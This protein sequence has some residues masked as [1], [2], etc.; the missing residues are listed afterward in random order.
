MGSRKLAA[1]ALSLGL[2]LTLTACGGD[3]GNDQGRTQEQSQADEESNLEEATDSDTNVDTAAEFEGTPEEIDQHLSI[4]IP[5][6]WTM[7]SG[8]IP[9]LDIY[10]LMV[11]PEDLEREELEPEAGTA[12]YAYLTVVDIGKT[13]NGAERY[14]K[15]IMESDAENTD[16][17]SDL[18]E[19]E[20]VEV[21]ETM[22]Y[23][24]EGTFTQQG[25]V[26]PFQSWHADANGTTYVIDIHG[27]VEGAIPE[28][29]TDAFHSIRFGPAQY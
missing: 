5:D 4:T 6:G 28:E 12:D 27:D 11:V 1:G 3:E 19:L 7:L 26:T 15:A 2:L 22:F 25:I 9:G 8:D 14:S 16:F 23:G 24:Y 18:A 29:L 20:P 13:R 21:G 10:L 17:Y